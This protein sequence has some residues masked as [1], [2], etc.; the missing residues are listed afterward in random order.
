MSEVKEEI[1]YRSILSELGY[2]LQDSGSCWRTQAVYRGGKNSGSL[3]IFKE[4]GVWVDFG[5]DEKYYPFLSLVGKTSGENSVIYEK[6]KGNTHTE[7]DVKEFEEVR[8][9]IPTMKK[10][11]GKDYFALLPHHLFY[12]KKGIKKETLEF[13]QGGLAMSKDSMSRRYVFPVVDE[14]GDIIGYNGRTIIEGDNRAKWKILGG[15]KNFRY[16]AFLKDRLG[17]FPVIEAIEE[18]SEV[19][20]IESVGDSLSLVEHN[21]KNNIVTFGLT[22]SA[23]VISFLNRFSDLAIFICLNNDYSKDVNTGKVAAVKMFLDLSLHFDSSRIKICL[24]IKGDFGDMLGDNEAYRDWE[25]KKENA[26]K[27]DFTKTVVTMAEKLLTVSVKEGGIPQRYRK[28]I[29]NLKD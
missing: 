11:Y 19:I 17:K 7:E 29:K 21:Y 24:P 1:D 3:L 8:E 5:Y 27:L 9:G 20:L 16:P 15:K 2:R 6:V 22:I 18:K 4:T 10:I 23:D 28:N 13:F 14:N 12:T 26:S 25:A